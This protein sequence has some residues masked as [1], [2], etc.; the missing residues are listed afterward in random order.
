MTDEQ[1]I[2][3]VESADAVVEEI[4][5]TDGTVRVLYTMT[6]RAGST[7]YSGCAAPEDQLQAL[8][9]KTLKKLR[10]LTRPGE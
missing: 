4:T 10:G 7:W 3:Q 9:S 1:T 2:R 8:L 6:L 5:R